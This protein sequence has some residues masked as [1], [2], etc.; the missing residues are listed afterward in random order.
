MEQQL[1]KEEAEEIDKVEVV[2]IGLGT[3]IFSQ[4]DLIEIASIL[5]ESFRKY[6]EKSIIYPLI[7]SYNLLI[8]VESSDQLS[9]KLSIETIYRSDAPKESIIRTIDEIID[10]CYKDIENYLRNK[11][12]A[13]KNL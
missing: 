4:E 5:E 12:S 1:R 13:S 11:Y 6:F 8:K 10:K 7:K 9:I 2:E 3:K